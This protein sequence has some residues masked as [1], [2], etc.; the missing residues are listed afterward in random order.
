M[1]G[2]TLYKAP[3]DTFPNLIPSG[4]TAGDML[5]KNLNRKSFE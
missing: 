4:W 3:I 5:I 1:L 2:L